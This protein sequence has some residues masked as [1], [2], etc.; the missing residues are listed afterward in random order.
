MFFRKANLGPKIS[1]TSKM[2]SNFIALI[3]N[4]VNIHTYFTITRPGW[5][6]FFDEPGGVSEL[7]WCLLE[8]IVVG[9]SS[10]SGI[11]HNHLSSHNGEMIALCL[12]DRI[13]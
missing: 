9:V 13:G 7:S 6:S 11:F 8:S 5:L 10:P 12:L 4:Q 1:V 2:N 3:I